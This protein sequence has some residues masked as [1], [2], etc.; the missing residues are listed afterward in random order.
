MKKLITSI[1]II[2][3][4]AIAYYVVTITPAQVLE[5]VGGIPRPLTE[6]EKTEVLESLSSGTIASGTPKA[7]TDEDKADVLKSLEGR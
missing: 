5:G 2:L 6:E 7:L 4:I 3:I 1:I